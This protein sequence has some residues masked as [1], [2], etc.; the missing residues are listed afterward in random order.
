MSPKMTK[1]SQ[2]S[3]AGRIQP[4]LSKRE[5]EIAQAY[6]SDMSHIEIAARIGRSPDTVRTHIKTIYRKLGVS[7]KLALAKHLD[8]RLSKPD[9]SPTALNYASDA[10]RQFAVAKENALSFDPRRQSRALD[11][12]Q[13]IADIWP[14]FSQAHSGISF[15][16]RHRAFTAKARGD[17]AY[18]LE[19]ALVASENALKKNFFDAT[20]QVTHGRALMLSDDIDQ[21]T[22]HFQIALEL[23]NG[24]D[25]ARY[26]TMQMTLF[27]G[28]TSESIELGERT[29]IAVREKFVIAPLELTLALAYLRAGYPTKARDYAQRCVTRSNSY[30]HIVNVATLVITDGDIAD[31]SQNTSIEQEVSSEIFSPYQEAFIGAICEDVLSLAERRS[32]NLSR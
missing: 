5:M 13:Q 22:R 18:F 9:V 16:Q 10:L 26:M 30:D 25:W 28:N 17:A 29:A 3:G 31:F 8:A 11:Q 21:A 32:D 19:S 20:A 23:D 2:V 4:T 1:H 27:K 7:S 6:S 24:S 12:F 14:D 15:C